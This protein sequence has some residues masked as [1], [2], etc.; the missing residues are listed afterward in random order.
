MNNVKTNNYI[1]D[2]SSVRLTP[3]N[4]GKKLRL[5]NKN[6]SIVNNNKS[7]YF[8]DEN[9]IIIGKYYNKK[10]IERPFNNCLV[11]D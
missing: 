11:L 1:N 5:E 9:N 3:Y 4:S 10:E 8:K 6:N 2:F 7:K